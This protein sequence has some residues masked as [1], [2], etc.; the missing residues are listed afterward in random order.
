MAYTVFQSGAPLGDLSDLAWTL[1]G[2]E[3]KTMGC[4]LATQ[5]S[6]DGYEMIFTEALTG[7]EEANVIVIANDLSLW[8]AVDT[9][10]VATLPAQVLPAACQVWVMDALREGGGTGTYAYWD[11]DNWLRISDNTVLA[12]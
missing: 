10:K 2:E 7:P 11:G 8:C 3:P 5:N 1:Q 4:A 6:V 9:Y 12:V